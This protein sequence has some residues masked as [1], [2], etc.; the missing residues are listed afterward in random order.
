M[1]AIE[2]NGNRVH[3]E[4]EHEPGP[5]KKVLR[6][7][8]GVLTFTTQAEAEAAAEAMF[9]RDKAASLERGHRR[10]LLRASYVVVNLEEKK[11]Y[12]APVLRELSADDPRVKTMRATPER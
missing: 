8:G 9:D 5:E 4:G 1:F 10:D 12:V 3:D 2:V 6:P 7:G 11:P